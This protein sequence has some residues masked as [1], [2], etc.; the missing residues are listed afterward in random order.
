L[1]DRPRH[2]RKVVVADQRQLHR[3]EQNRRIDE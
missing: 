3:L 2:D 1:S